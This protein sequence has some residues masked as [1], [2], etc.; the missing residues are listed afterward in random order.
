MEKNGI[1]MRIHERRCRQC[2][3]TI[4]EITVNTKRAQDTFVITSVARRCSRGHL[5][6]CEVAD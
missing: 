6:P 4:P 2:E 1:P 5:Q 3:E